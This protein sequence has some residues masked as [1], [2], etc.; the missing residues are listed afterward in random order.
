MEIE[1]PGLGILRV[2]LE[3]TTTGQKCIQAVTDGTA[4]IPGT[5][6]A[7]TLPALSAWQT[8]STSGSLVDW[9]TGATPSV[10]IPIA[11][12]EILHVAYAFVFV[13]VDYLVSCE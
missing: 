3:F 4:A 8:R 10:T 7:I 13:I 2:P 6:S 12:S 11:T 9:T 1:N 5:T